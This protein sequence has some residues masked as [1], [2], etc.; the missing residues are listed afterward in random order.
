MRRSRCSKEETRER[1]L[2]KAQELFRLY[3]FGKTTVAELAAELGMSPANVYKFFPS[4]SAIVEACAARGVDAIRREVLG[5]VGSGGAVMD[6]IGR[7]VLAIYRFNHR[8]LRN[9]RQIFKLAAAALDGAWPCMRAYREFLHETMERLVAE[10]V[11][12]G[13]FAAAPPS[14]TATALL[15]CLGAPLRAHLHPD[16]EPGKNQERRIRSQI[17]FLARAL[18]FSP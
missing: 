6:R 12:S 16:Y 5:I 18:Q 8:M 11:K 10:G 13:E 9:E 17:H 7:V 14:R 3:G 1:I 4:K 2:A 15:D